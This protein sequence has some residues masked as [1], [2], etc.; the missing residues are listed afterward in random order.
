[1]KRRPSPA[2]SPMAIAAMVA[3]LRPAE[4]WEFSPPPEAV[5]GKSPRGVFGIAAKAGGD[6]ATGDVLFGG[7]ES[8]EGMVQR[9]LSGLPQRSGFP[10]KSAAFCLRKA[11]E[12][13]ISPEKLLKE[14]SSVT[15][16]KSLDPSTPIRTV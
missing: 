9:I 2:R 8:V 10:T 5:P 16:D 14:R 12:G 7:F 11:S 13:G 1:M 4:L 6:S 15:L 3:G